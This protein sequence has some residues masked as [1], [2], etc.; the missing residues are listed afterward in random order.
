MCYHERMKQLITRIDER[1]H[2][3]LKA[4]A[5]TEGRSVNALVTEVL[6]AAV[7]ELDMRAQVRARMVA[8]GALVVSPPLDGDV[9]TMEE[10]LALTRGDAG[11]AILEALEAD[12]NSR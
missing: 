10:V 2:G 8:A 3:R 5:Q 11:R 7:P 4:R 6:E 1:L 12:R 9:P